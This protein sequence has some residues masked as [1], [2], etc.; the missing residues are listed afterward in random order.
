ME[1]IIKPKTLDIPRSSSGAAVS[2]N[3]KQRYIDGIGELNAKI[4][5]ILTDITDSANSILKNHF[6]DGQNV[7][8]ISLS[9]EG[10]FK[11]DLIKERIWNDRRQGRR[12]DALRI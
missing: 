10:K 5:S 3:E 7:I 8:R 4:Q 11:F 6:Y 12:H 1:E 2:R 9:F